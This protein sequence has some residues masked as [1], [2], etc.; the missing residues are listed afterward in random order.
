MLL[1][2]EN[3]IPHARYGDKKSVDILKAAGFDAIG[4]SFNSMYDFRETVYAPGAAEQ[5]A[6]LSAYAAERGMC[7][8]QGHAPYEFTYGMRLDR[9]EEKYEDIVRAMRY[10]ALLGI[11]MIVVHAV[12]VPSGVDAM[13]Y[14]LRF[15]RSLLPYAEELGIKIAVENLYE[16]AKDGSLR[17]KFGTPESFCGLIDRL[18]S[19]FITGCVDV[20]HAHLTT[21]D[22]PGFLRAAGHR[23]G[24][25]HIHENDGRR[26]DHLLPAI[27]DHNA[28]YEPVVAHPYFTVPWPEVFAA[29]KDIGYA[30]NL[31]LE[32]HRYMDPFPS[33]ILP[34]ALHLAASVGKAM[35]R[36]LS[37]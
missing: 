24:C 19:P 14:N 15:Y 16:K 26:D 25:L 22:A 27:Y 3:V 30:G 9:A 4:Y 17:P 28:P 31:D 1:L 13:D 12:S 32:I 2:T 36:S 35:I 10:A 33:D 20:G 34:E 6:D 8:A 29:L 23:V 18:D 11:P 5:A 7:F 21:H 37:A